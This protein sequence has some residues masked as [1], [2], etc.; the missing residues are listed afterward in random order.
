MAAR[1]VPLWRAGWGPRTAGL[2][3]SA[4]RAVDAEAAA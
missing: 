3:A 4:V 1:R 2:L